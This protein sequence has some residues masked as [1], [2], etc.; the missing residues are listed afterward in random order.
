M[1]RALTPRGQHTR[2]QP[3]LVL[4]QSRAVQVLYD[5]LIVAHTIWSPIV[6]PHCAATSGR[7]WVSIMG[8]GGRG[9]GE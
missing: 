7:V 3:E 5:T 9:L 6:S 8:A 2:E 1:N 4:R